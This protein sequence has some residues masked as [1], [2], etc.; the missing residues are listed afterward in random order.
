MNAGQARRRED[1]DRRARVDAC[2]RQGRPNDQGRNHGS[3]VA[4]QRVPVLRGNRQGAL[5]RLVGQQDREDLIGDLAR[6]LSIQNADR[7]T[8]PSILM[9]SVWLAN[10]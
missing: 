4:N 3:V 1:H 6:V 7:N 5:V 10:F 9:A 2:R 8:S